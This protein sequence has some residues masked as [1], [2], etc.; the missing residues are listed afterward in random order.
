MTGLTE[1]V[2]QTIRK[3]DIRPTPRW[4]FL[5]IEGGKIL[6]LAA[7][8]VASSLAV[9]ATLHLFTDF[10]WEGGVYRADNWLNY[11]VRGVPFF[12]LAVVLVFLVAAA[13]DFY[14]T[15]DGYRYRRSS[16]VAA[17]LGASLVL[18]TVMYG[19]GYGEDVDAAM[20]R[21]WGGYRRVVW[22]RTDV[23]SQP[24]EGLLGGV[25]ES[26]RPEPPEMIVRDF[27]RR[28]WLVRPRGSTWPEP[29]PR[30]VHNAVI[31]IIGDREDGL[32]FARE[33]RPWVGRPPRINP[34]Y[35]N[36]R[37]EPLEAPPSDEAKERP[38]P[39]RI[40]R[41]GAVQQP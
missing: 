30:L 6:L 7:T 23:W 35:D 19:R 14:S 18:G 25:V 37:G 5:M 41:C 27:E 16:V 15:T 29:H 38:W 12:W 28:I 17:C 32:F 2:L 8:V 9:S 11:A 20:E 31:R 13:L 24:D 36:C 34:L 22:S 40:I 39:P 4:R 21:S 3:R 1:K 10:E 33:I 26:V